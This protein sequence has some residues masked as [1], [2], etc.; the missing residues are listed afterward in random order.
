MST[1]PK[2]VVK[3]FT[4]RLTPPLSQPSGSQLALRRPSDHVYGPLMRVLLRKPNV[5]GL[6]TGRL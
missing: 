2:L 1:H 6:Y 3:L 5:I 4:D